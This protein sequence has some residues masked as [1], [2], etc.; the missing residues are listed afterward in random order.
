MK[1][2]HSLNERY[3]SYLYNHLWLKFTVDYGTAFIAS[4]LSAAI[5]AFGIVCFLNPTLTEGQTTLELVSG[6]SSGLAQVIASLLRVLGVQIEPGNTLFFSIA[7]LAVN[8]PLIVLAFKGVGVRFASFTL[9]NVLFVFLF[10][11]IF[12]GQFF[13]EIAT[14]MNT[15]GGFLA[16]ALF[17][18]MC[19]GLSSAIAYKFETSAGGFD[20]VSYYV[21]LRKSTT[22]GKYSVMINAVIITM[23]Y[24]IYGFGGGTSSGFAGYSTWATAF[25]CVFFSVV[26]LFTVMLVVDAINVRNKKVQI[27]VN[28]TNQELPRLLLARIPHGLTVVKAKGAYSGQDRL[29]LYLVVSSL[30]VKS[31][32]KLIKEVDPTSF[33]T[34][35]SLIQVYGRFFSQKV[36]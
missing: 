25:A 29:L 10:S 28:T 13:Q 20:I 7:Y 4:V 30:E 5:F 27:E 15:E 6:G 17:A 23:F 36:R 9:I 16:R 1:Q 19:T 14:L 12:K 31:A 21:S 35:K 24:L 18:G 33:V 3:H 2:K 34:V 22:A 26:Y 8:A 11:N 32:L